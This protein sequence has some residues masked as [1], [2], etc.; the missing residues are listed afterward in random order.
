MLENNGPEK[1]LGES[2][3]RKLGAHH[4]SSMCSGVLQ[5]MLTIISSKK[6]EAG[7]YGSGRGDAPGESEWVSSD[8][9]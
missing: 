7:S 2:L 1:Q 9:C 4:S 6:T 5:T 3:L 8:S